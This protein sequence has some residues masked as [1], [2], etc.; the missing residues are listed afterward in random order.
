MECETRKGQRCEY[1][2]GETYSQ[3]DQ[4]AIWVNVNGQLMSGHIDRNGKA[5]DLRPYKSMFYYPAEKAMQFTSAQGNIVGLRV[6][7]T[8]NIVKTNTTATITATVMVLG[9][10]FKNETT[11]SREIWDYVEQTS[12]KGR[13]AARD[14]CYRDMR[15][16]TMT[17]REWLELADPNREELLALAQFSGPCYKMLRNRVQ[18]SISRERVPDKPI[19]KPV[20]HDQKRRRNEI[21]ALVRAELL[22][23]KFRAVQHRLFLLRLIK[24]N[25]NG[26]FGS[27]EEG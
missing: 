26:R 3:Y 10:E 14:E 6:P 17:T 19:Y 5:A 18:Y 16:A 8:L 1:L 23:R 22:A 13:I 27:F 7:A 9:I 11:H 24:E 21:L 25:E 4:K 20:D 15:M 2:L 12:E